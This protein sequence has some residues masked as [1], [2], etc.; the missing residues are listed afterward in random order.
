MTIG[1]FPHVPIGFTV[2][3]YTHAY[4]YSHHSHIGHIPVLL[5]KYLA[6]L[7]PFQDSVLITLSVAVVVYIAAFW[8]F[9]VKV[10]GEEHL[11]MVTCFTNLIGMLAS[12]SRTTFCETISFLNFNLMPLTLRL[13]CTIRQEFW[14]SKVF[15]VGYIL[16]TTVLIFA[17]SGNLTASIAMPGLTKVPRTVEDLAYMEDIKIWFY[18]YGG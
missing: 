7:G 8:L 2:A 1:G 6:L 11:T 14:S 18:K 3:T 17:Y 13:G 4:T 12:Q 15:L 16:G 9:V 10:R 5:P